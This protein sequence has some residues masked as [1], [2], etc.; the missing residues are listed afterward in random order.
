MDKQ[1]PVSKDEH[2]LKL[3]YK[4]WDLREYLSLFVLEEDRFLRAKRKAIV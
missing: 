2:N 1:V 3:D 4:K